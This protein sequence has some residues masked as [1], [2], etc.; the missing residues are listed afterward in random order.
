VPFWFCIWDDGNVQ[1]V[2]EHGVT[3]EEF[4]EVVSDPEN[5][6]TSHRTGR[7]IAFGHTGAGRYLRACTR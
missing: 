3:P 4:E 2:A 1:H 6:D 5:L 7:P